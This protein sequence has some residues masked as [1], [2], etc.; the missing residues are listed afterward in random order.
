MEATIYGLGLAGPQPSTCYH[1]PPRRPPTNLHK[2]PHQQVYVKH[3]SDHCANQI[4][5][6]RL[7]IFES[8]HPRGYAVVPSGWSLALQHVAS[9]D[10]WISESHVLGSARSRG[11]LLVFMLAHGN[12]LV[13]VL[14]VDEIIGSC[15]RILIYSK[16]G[17]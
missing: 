13:S 3:R 17:K 10:K 11:H 8:E 5:S 2:C 12:G 14:F 15:Q 16:K 7:A 4:F 6:L 9:C 1:Q